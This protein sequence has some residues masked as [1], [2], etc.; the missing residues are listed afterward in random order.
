MLALLFV[1]RT[2]NLAFVQL[3]IQL[4]MRRNRRHC[5]V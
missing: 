5:Q 3:V 2:D 4:M 1:K